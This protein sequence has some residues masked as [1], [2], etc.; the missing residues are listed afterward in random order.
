MG[1]MINYKDTSLY[2]NREMSW[3]LFDRRVLSEAQDK[4]IPLFER[5]KFLS[6]TASNLDEFF[7][8]R[9]ASLQDMVNAGYKKED[10]SGLTP[11]KQL[12]ILDKATH[13][14]VKE[15]YDVYR[16]QLLPELSLNHFRVIEHHE[17]LTQSE[18]E[19]VDRYFMDHVYPVLT[20]MAVDSSRPFPLIRNKSLNLGALVCKKN[21]G[22]DLEFV[23]VQVPAVLSRIVEI[24]TE[25]EGTAVILLEEII[26]RNIRKLF[27]NYDI[28]CVSPF[29]IM[30][31]ADLTI[32]EDE[33]EDL[34]KEIEKQ[35]RKRQWGQVIRLEVESGMDARLLGIIKEELD[36]A[37][38][39]IYQI[40]GPLDLT[41]LMKAYGA[42]GYDTLKGE[43]YVPVDHPDLVGEYDI[44][45]KIREKDILLH[46]PYQTFAPVVKFVKDAADD[47]NVLAIK[48]TDRKSVV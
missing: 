2:T 44:F 18:G 35:V 7:M 34:L 8:V 41:F 37:T 38:S 13:D 43:K 14:L 3:L 19:Y 16:K 9:V 46:H 12:S 25:D 21:G 28:V 26:E 36:I 31:N 42:Y 27:L 11:K 29:R 32:E 20:P 17:M 22:S 48:Q 40:H 4:T 10:I 5:L 23:T 39:G 47:P 33:A 45:E 15:Q 1:E 30:R 24:P 6:I